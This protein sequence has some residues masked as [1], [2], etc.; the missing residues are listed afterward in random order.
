MAKTRQIDP[1][2][3]ILYQVDLEVGTLVVLPGQDKTM[4]EHWFLYTEA[5]RTTGVYKRPVNSGPDHITFN[6]QTPDGTIQDACDRMRTLG[7]PS[8]DYIECTAKPKTSPCQ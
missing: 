2:F 4:I 6:K 5:G 3:Y 8:H 1:G 7:V